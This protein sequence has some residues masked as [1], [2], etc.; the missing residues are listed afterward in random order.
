MPLL[1]NK[2]LPMTETTV[3]KQNMIRELQHVAITGV[4]VW[5]ISTSRRVDLNQWIFAG[6]D[7]LNV[8]HSLEMVLRV[9]LLSV[10]SF[11]VFFILQSLVYLASWW[12]WS[13]NQSHLPII[14]CSLCFPYY[15]LFNVI[16]FPSFSVSAI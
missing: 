14:N 4:L 1:T 12:H 3:F 16:W 7:F 2:K 15:R 6:Q 11:L 10:R 8:H 5:M 13:V 9:C